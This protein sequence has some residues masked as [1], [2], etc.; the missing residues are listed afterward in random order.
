MD[1]RTESGPLAGTHPGRAAGGYVASEAALAALKAHPKFDAAW[2]PM[3]HSLV[4]EYRGMRLLNGLI[5]DCGRNAVAVLA[6]Y[7]HRAADPDDPRSGLTV[8]RLKAICADQDIASPGRIEALLMLMRAGGLIRPA[9]AGGDRRVRRLEPTERLIAILHGRWNELL[10]AMTLVLPEAAAVRAAMD[11][12]A[13]ERA[14]VLRFGS[15][16]LAGF[17]LLDDP[18]T[19]GM[20][21]ERNAGLMV[22]FTLVTATDPACRAPVAVSISALARQFSVSRV[23]IRKMLRD[24]VAAGYIAWPDEREATIVV[25]PPLYEAVQNFFA[26]GILFMLHCANE[27]FDELPAMRARAVAQAS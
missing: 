22:A 21:A 12:A 19:M 27:V 8:S 23:H 16:F 6:L 25:L 14:M 5:N 24:A 2:R 18:E 4:K 26:N 13:F 20:F 3:A 15:Y 7:L 1:A 10:E 17:R 11:D 9:P